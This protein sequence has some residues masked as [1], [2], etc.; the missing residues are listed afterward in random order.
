M[1]AL[2]CRPWKGQSVHHYHSQNCSKEAKK[3]SPYAKRSLNLSRVASVVL[4]NSHLPHFTRRRYLPSFC[5]HSLQYHV[6]TGSFVMP[7]QFQWNH[8]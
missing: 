6:P 4:W 3:H 1:R 2:I 7:T 8:S 5:L